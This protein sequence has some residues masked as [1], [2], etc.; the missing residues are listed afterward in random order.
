MRCRDLLAFF[1]DDWR[2]RAELDRFGVGTFLLAFLGVASEKVLLNMSDDL[3]SAATCFFISWA[4]LRF[5]A[6]RFLITSALEFV[7]G[8][9]TVWLSLA[10]GV[11][12]RLILCKL[13]N[14]AF[15]RLQ[16]L[17]HLCIGVRL[18]AFYS[19][20]VFGTGLVPTFEAFLSRFPF[21]LCG[22]GVLF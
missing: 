3:S 12:P 21:G 2:V 4:T 17:N 15:H 16:V 13:G 1:A 18:W 9:F 22:K 5:T 19:L 7:F 14:A 10:P 11:C 8:P 20:T 6:F